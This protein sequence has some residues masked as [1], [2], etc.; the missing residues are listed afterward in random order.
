M[1][2][3]GGVLTKL[4]VKKLKV[5]SMRVVEGDRGLLRVGLNAQEAV[6]GNRSNR[7]GR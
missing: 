7:L 1:N 4:G 5:A 2:L 6:A 3:G